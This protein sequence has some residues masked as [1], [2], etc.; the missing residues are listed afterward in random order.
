VL[1]FQPIRLRL[2]QEAT[3]LIKYLVKYNSAETRRH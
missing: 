3:V 2:Q 1:A